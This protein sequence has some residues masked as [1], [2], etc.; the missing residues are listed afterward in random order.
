MLHVLPEQSMCQA[1]DI[2]IKKP[3]GYNAIRLVSKVTPVPS[4]RTPQR[5]FVYAVA[6][7]E[8]TLFLIFPISLSLPLLLLAGLALPITPPWPSADA[9]PWTSHSSFQTAGGCSRPRTMLR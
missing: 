8:L 6:C 4:R 9:L 2:N 7:P 1:P 5:P 3:G